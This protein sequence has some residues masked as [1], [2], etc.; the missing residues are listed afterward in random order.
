M[1]ASAVTPT[2]LSAITTWCMLCHLIRIHGPSCFFSN[3]LSPFLKLLNPGVSFLLVLFQCLTHYSKFLFVARP[4]SL[5]PLGPHYNSTVN[6]DVFYFIAEVLWL[7]KHLRYYEVAYLLT[8]II[9]DHMILGESQTL[10]RYSPNNAL[11]VSS[12]ILLWNLKV[13][14]QS[15]MVI[16]DVPAGAQIMYYTLV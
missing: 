6:K 12:F 2:C 4:Q 15:H 10:S 1:K 13:A 14:S 11:V 7:H 8:W 3:L 16:W 9:S 5:G